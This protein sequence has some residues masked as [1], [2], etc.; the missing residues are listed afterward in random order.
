MTLEQCAG[1]RGQYQGGRCKNRGISVRG[2]TP[3]STVVRPGAR[4]SAVYNS[5]IRE[6]N[7]V[8]LLPKSRFLRVAF[9]LSLVISSWSYCRAAAT[10]LV[11]GE[12]ELTV[13]ILGLTG[14][15]TMAVEFVN[16]S[17]LTPK[18]AEE[19]RRAVLAKLADRGAHL[20]AAEQAAATVRI[21]LSEDLQ[22]YVW[23]AEVHQGLSDAP[24]ILV[25]LPRPDVQSAQAEAALLVLHKALLWSQEDRI[26]DAAVIDGNP[27]HMAVLDANR[28]TIYK[29]Q[30]S[31]WHAEQALPIAHSKPWP[32][33]LRGRL[34]LRKDHLF[35]AYL[36]GVFCRSSANAPLTMTCDHS[37]D[38]WPIG[39]ENSSLN[40]F[41]AGSRNFFTGALAPGIGKQT[42]APAFYSAAALPRENYTLW[43]FAATDGRLHLLDGMADQSTGKLNWGSEIAALRSDC[44]SGWQVLASGNAEGSK[45]TLRAF[46]FADRD[47]IAVS[48]PLEFSGTITALWT[49]STGSSAVAVARDPQTERY[50]AFRIT[51]ACNR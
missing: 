51:L 3:E 39:L 4:R 15:G 20:V 19:I 43:L 7:K 6:T 28:V 50:E 9:L 45:D 25:S 33:D 37:D 30:N 49:D 46:E 40:A 13:R 11:E 16:R 17:S 32:R 41:Y 48:Q 23:I 35:D 14:P 10:N 5:P 34:V 26:L 31:G 8:R 12:E 2:V 22:N 47:P 27:A 29:L 1:F 44:G 38:P 21:S 42:A 18:D 36:P 24:A